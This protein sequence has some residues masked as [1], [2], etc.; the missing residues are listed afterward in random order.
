M[1][2]QRTLT[3][4]KPTSFDN[5]EDIFDLIRKK[6]FNILISKVFYLSYEDASI[7]YYE[8]HSKPFFDEMVQNMCAG[9]VIAVVLEKENAVADFRT[10]LGAT[11][12]NEAEDGTIRKLFGKSKKQNA[13]HGSDSLQS[14]KSE[15][16]FFF[17]LDGFWSLKNLVFL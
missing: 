2:T 8:H 11:D 15:I 14:A 1:K 4:I 17:Y 3:M 9:P 12:P 7:F 16:K 13:V 10:I 5:A 6:G